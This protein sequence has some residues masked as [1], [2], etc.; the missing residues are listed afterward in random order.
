MFVRSLRERTVRQEYGL[1][2]AQGD[3]L[4]AELM[5]AGMSVERLFVQQNSALGSLAH[6]EICT[7]E[8]MERM[9]TLKSAPSSLALVKMPFAAKSKR[10]KGLTLVL[11]GV[12]DPGN[13]GTI[14]RLAHWWGVQQ[15]YCSDSCA[16]CYCS[17]VIQSTMGAIAAVEVIYGDLVDFLKGVRSEDVPVYGTFLR[18]SSS[19]YESQLA[20]ND[21]VIVMGSE[22]QGISVEVE[23]L[24]SHRIF[25]P[26]Y[27]EDAPAAESLNVAVATTVVVSEFRRQIT[28]NK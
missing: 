3:K 15:I 17:K 14:I 4:I 28:Q 21:A 23:A 1:F 25:I 26:P 6:A 20:P 10:R 11:D 19:L 8:Q 9:S 13:L 7:K 12:Q 24:V 16:D 2:V 22:G 18:Q 27:P 5:G